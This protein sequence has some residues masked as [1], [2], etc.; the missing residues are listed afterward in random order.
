MKK[1]FTFC[2]FAFALLIGTQT[3]FAQSNKVNLKEKAY[4]QVKELRQ[5]IK[6]DDNTLEQIYNAQYKYEKNLVLL[7]EEHQVETEG[8]ISGLNTL[9]Y[10][11]QTSIKETLGKDLFKRYLIL[12]D[13]EEILP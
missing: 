4:L 10:K 12:S 9:T 5:H 6:I 2:F 7:K 8:Y 13:Q 11:L 3:V 1:L